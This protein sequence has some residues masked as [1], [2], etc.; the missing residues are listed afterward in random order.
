MVASG[1]DYLYFL[2][3]RA[4]SSFFVLLGVLLIV[5][6]ISH[7]VSHDPARLWAGPKARPSTVEAVAIRFHLNDP[8][9][10]QLYYFILDFFTLNFGIDPLTGQ[11]ISSEIGFYLPNTLELVFAAL[12]MILVAGIG[13]GYIAGM[14]F[15]GKKDSAIRV[16]YLV[17]W[18]TPTFLGAIG[19]VLVFAAYLKLLPSGGMY[20]PGLVPPPHITGI[21]VLD[22]LLSLNFADMYSGLSHLLLPAA[23]LAFLNFGLIARI[24]RSSVIE[25]RW[26]PHVKAA[27]AKGLRP[28]EVNR[29][30]V[31][32]NS[33]I[34]V[35]T[36]GAVMFGWLLSGTVVIEQVFAWPGIGSFTYHAIAADDY[37]ALIP[38]ILVFATG[39]IVANLAADIIY[40]VLDPRIAL[41]ESR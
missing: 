38:A 4:L 39:V 3:K 10:V 15:G 6:L 20:A 12:A 2:A 19:F 8:L 31:L 9:P 11:S 24:A 35:D 18:S 32:R 5:F 17:S 1:R 33:L 16:L 14:N 25:N 23:A 21:F 30:H 40:S 34:D 27:T 26:A 41:G 29:R 28:S 22:S 37:P 36:V 13:L 7:V